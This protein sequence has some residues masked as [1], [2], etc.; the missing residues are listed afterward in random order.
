M[1]VQKYKKL[2]KDITLMINIMEE[3]K[4]VPGFSIYSASK[5]G[6][7]KND[8]TQRTLTPYKTLNGYTSLNMKNDQ[9]KIKSITVHRIIA[10]TWIPNPENKLTVN[11]KN[12]IR[13]DNR[14]ENL[15]WAT[16][17]EQAEHKISFNKNNN[18]SI[19]NTMKKSV[20]KCDLETKERLTYYGSLRDAST[21]LNGTQKGER[22]IGQCAL[23]RIDSA[24]GFF[25]E[26]GVINNE[27]DN[28]EN[29]N[30]VTNEK[31]ELYK[32]TGRSTYY[33][34]DHGNVKNK[35]KLLK[36][37]KNDR[38]YIIISINGK[39]V[40]VHRMVAEQFIPNPN[41]YGV[42]NHKDGNKSNN[43]S[44]N[45]EWV[46]DKENS[47]HAVDTGLRKNI[48]KV[49]QYDDN[50]NIIKIF[51][52]ATEAGKMLNINFRLIHIHCKGESSMQNYKFKYLS[53]ADDSINNK[54]DINT[55]PVRRNNIQKKKV[56]QYDDNHNIIN[57]FNSIDECAETL[58][59]NRMTVRKYCEG[60]PKKKADINLKSLSEF[61]DLENKKIDVKTLP[62][63]DDH[64]IKNEFNTNK[65]ISIYNKND[66]M[67]IE[68]MNDHNEI[69]KKYGLAFKTIIKH[70]NG[71]IK[72]SKSQYNF[73]FA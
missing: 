63:I 56:V 20:W 58:N 51:N 4:I 52:S 2:L 67:L 73:K 31:W 47:Q 5:L 30:N 59:L 44:T 40:I 27:N 45:L 55:I 36:K 33:I 21:D 60:K 15:E 28:N 24:F 16:N 3:W 50:N 70:C 46:T 34:S 14:M 48:R 54:I 57:V 6:N 35:E 64:K 18:V 17:Q 66:G 9:H 25:W 72:Y 23:G 29:V 13:D 22:E 38:G 37:S 1:Y 32:K 39:V 71:E 65:A 53:D 41:K 69:S 26:Y 10:Q 68:T 43:L 49:I 8:E 61:D 42:V 7:V 19:D 12:K 62:K 11:H